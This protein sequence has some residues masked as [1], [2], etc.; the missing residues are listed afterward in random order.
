M[1]SNPASPTKVN[2]QVSDLR[3]M[4]VAAMM[5]TN[6]DHARGYG[7]QV[8]HV[9]FLLT[10]GQAGGMEWTL[11]AVSLWGLLMCACP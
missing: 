11:V 1:G 10:S 9:L 6:V 2:V 4:S 7:R 3:R 5:S 8:V